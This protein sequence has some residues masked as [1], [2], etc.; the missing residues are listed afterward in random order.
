MQMKKNIFEK[1]VTEHFSDQSNLC[2]HLKM[3]TG[4]KIH[5]CEIC[6][7]GFSHVGHLE[8]HLRTHKD[9]SL[10]FVKFVTKDIQREKFNRHFRM[11]TRGKFFIKDF[12][13]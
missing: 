2:K 7:K 13:T 11:R 5:V 10:M 1:F 4:E 9:K 3:H 6:N 12:R 8:I